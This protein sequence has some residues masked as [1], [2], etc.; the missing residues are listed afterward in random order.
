[1]DA[2]EPFVGEDLNGE[3]GPTEEVFDV[4]DSGSSR[5]QGEGVGEGRVIEGRGSGEDFDVFLGR[6]G[7]G[8]VVGRREEEDRWGDGEEEDLSNQ[9]SNGRR[10]ALIGGLGRKIFPLFW[11]KCLR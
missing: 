5:G 6:L 4:N 3:G 8:E 1:M 11:K 9:L 10:P 7:E 2:G